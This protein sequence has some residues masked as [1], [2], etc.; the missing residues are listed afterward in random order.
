MRLLSPPPQ[1][2][3]HFLLTQ[4]GGGGQAGGGAHLVLVDCDGKFDTLRL[5]QV[6]E[7]GRGGRREGGRQGW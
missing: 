5:L 3:T 2:I 1:I 6:R 4:A 7:E